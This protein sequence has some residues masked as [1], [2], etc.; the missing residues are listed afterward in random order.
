MSHPR[1]GHTVTLLPT[2]QVLA[3]GGSSS[4][5]NGT[6]ASSAELYDPA[7]KRWT[8]AA[9]MNSG[10]YEFTA[11]L[12]RNGQV[13][14]AG[15][16]PPSSA[17]GVA[18]AEI[19]DPLADAWTPVGS[20]STTRWSH[21]AVLL[22]DGRV[23]VCG[24]VDSSLAVLSTCETY[25]P[26]TRQWTPASSMSAG[27]NGTSLV[28][29]G[30]ASV[31]AAGGRAAAA[32]KL[33][34][35]EYGTNPSVQPVIASVNGH[36]TF[37]VVLT[38]TQDWMDTLGT[39]LIAL[40]EGNSPPT[41]SDLSHVYL[42]PDAGSG[43]GAMA[44]GAY[45]DQT[46]NQNAQF[47]DTGELF[48][49][50]LYGIGSYYFSYVVMTNGVPSAFRR[51]VSHPI[52][53]PSTSPLPPGGGGGTAAA[54]AYPVPFAPSRGHRS[55]NF[56]NLAGPGTI[57]VYTVS[58]EK[59]WSQDFS[60]GTLQAPW[61]V[62]NDHAETVVSGVYLFVVKDQAGKSTGKLVVLR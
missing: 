25:D 33:Y 15:G 29:L 13:L 55:I 26:A 9:S 60:A 12:L 53:P 62:Q 42:V 51:V 47:S 20:M 58:G 8:P 48:I 61:N 32:E 22:P 5:V 6:V 34:F 45:S 10:R 31:L 7:A 30:D 50:S 23:L 16:L 14:V 2:G 4:D 28:L 21:M 44:T 49:A 39:G 36:S 17:V 19:Y 43:F 37:P 24:G 3:A 40:S 52:A 1:V 38:S 18:S 54:H 41:G 46:L 11:T 57:T 56:I 59:V 35:S 27:R